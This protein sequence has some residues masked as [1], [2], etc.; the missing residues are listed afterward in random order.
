MPAMMRQMLEPETQETFINPPLPTQQEIG[1]IPEEAKKDSELFS[2]E[3]VKKQQRMDPKL[4]DIFKNIAK[5]S[6]KKYYNSFHLENE[7]LYPE[8]IRKKKSI[9]DSYEA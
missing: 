5:N 8:N 1:Q 3:L 6:L 2:P 9:G 7:V 4:V